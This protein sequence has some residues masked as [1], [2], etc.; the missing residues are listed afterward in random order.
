MVSFFKRH[1]EKLIGGLVLVLFLSAV[2]WG[3]VAAVRSDVPLSEPALGPVTPGTGKTF[4]L[5]ESDRGVSVVPDADP[6]FRMDFPETL[7]EPVAVRLSENRKVTLLHEDGASFSLVPESSVTETPENATLLAGIRADSVSAAYRS[8]DDRRSVFYTYKELDREKKS[9]LF[10]QWTLYD[11]SAPSEKESY[12]LGNARVSIQADGSAKVHPNDSSDPDFL[13]PRPYYLDR[14]GS[15]TDLDWTYDTATRTLSVSFSAP[16]ESYPLA[17]D[18]SVLKTDTV[19][20]AFSGQPVSMSAPV[21]CGTSTVEGYG[22]IVYG[23]VLADDGNCWLDR[24]LGAT[25][26]ATSSTDT[27]SYGWYFQWGRDY[28]GHQ[29]PTSQ[30]TYTTSSTDTPGHG[31]FIL[32]PASPYDWRSPQNSNL[33]QGVSGINNPCPSGFRLPTQPEWAAL[34]SAEGITNPATAFSSN[35]KLPAAGNRG[36]LI[37][38]MSQN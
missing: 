13:I 6:S 18:P 36:S 5:T 31:N 28:D 20:A 37:L 24:N 1:A 34:V 22:D 9:F 21:V 4:S 12:S 11:T 15:K 27:A 26:V 25:R 30:T 23:T 2:V 8:S 14:N 35:L 32:S 33:W 10:K 29:I 17:L 3:I 7:A 38:S 16:A 19:I